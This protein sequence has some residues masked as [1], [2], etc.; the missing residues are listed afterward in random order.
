MRYFCASCFTKLKLKLKL[1]ANLAQR[2]GFMENF[3]RF[4]TLFKKIEGK[5]NEIFSKARQD[6]FLLAEENNRIRKYV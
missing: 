4:E 3:N 5:A 1:D 6:R 2:E